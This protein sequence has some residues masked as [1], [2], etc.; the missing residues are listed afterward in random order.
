MRFLCSLFFLFTCMHAEA[1]SLSSAQQQSLNGYVEFANRSVNDVEVRFHSLKSYAEEA[2]YYRKHKGMSLRLGSSGPLEEYYFNNALKKNTLPAG[3]A[4][5]LNT[6]ARHLRQIAEALDSKCK[7]LETYIRLE[8]YKRDDLE[9]SDALLVEI[10]ALFVQFSL[11]KESFQKQIQAVYRRHQPENDKDVYLKTE[12]EMVQVLEKEKDLLKA[13]NYYFNQEKPASWPLELFQKN[14]LNN[15]STLS[16]FGKNQ[17]V[18]GYP[19]ANVVSS[20]KAAIESMQRLK[21]NAIDSYTF[22]ARQSGKHGNKV[23]LDLIN[24]YN[25]DLLANYQAFVRYSSVVKYLLDYPKF[26]LV[27]EINPP[28]ISKPAEAS[29]ESFKDAPLVPIAKIYSIPAS[30]TAFDALS[31]YVEYINESLRQMNRLQL[32]LRNYQSSAEYYRDPATN[33]KRSGLTY[34]HE[35]Y[36]MPLSLYQQ[37]ISSSQHLPKEYRTTI[38]SQAE[39]LMNILKEMDGLSIELIAYTRDKKYQQDQLRRS[40]AILERYAFLFDAFDQKKEQLYHDVRRIHESYQVANPKDSWYVSGKALLATIDHDKEILFGVKAYLKGETSQLPPIDKM[41]ASVRALITDEY[42]NLKGLTRYGRSNGLCPYSPYEDLASNSKRFGEKANNLQN[43]SNKEPARAYEDFYYFYNNEL[44]YEYNKFSEL[45]KVGVLKYIN[46]P[47][48]FIWKKA[49]PKAFRPVEKAPVLEMKE[50]V[51]E[52]P[53]ALNKPQKPQPVE[54]KPAV[55]HEL[56]PPVKVVTVEVAKHDTVYL[57]RERVDTVYMDRG[58]KGEDFNS[59]KGYAP[60]NMVLL[61]DVSASMD[62]PNKMPLLKKSIK[63]LL[64]LMRP[65]DEVSIVVYSGKAK[66]ALEPTSGAEIDKIAHVIDQLESDG[67]TDG[68]AG[69]RLAYKVANKNYIRGGNNRIVLATDGEFPI[70]QNAYQWAEE[71]AREDIYLTVF[72]FSRKAAI[73]GNLQKLS[74]KGRGSY[75]HITKE[76]AHHKLV[77]EAKA[78][79][80]R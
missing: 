1:Q 78:K 38:L 9:Q 71:N 43:S 80:A 39:V 8:D 24:Y 2:D 75:E 27:F 32:L 17:A 34:S 69:I 19:A 45:A 57:E 3:E 37:I 40:D 26:S 54:A 65:E 42:Q 33:V 44:V 59:L 7:A 31:L 18:I 66:V 25:N 12:K 41:A 68:N 63:S 30:K 21:R 58:Q 76:N 62:S 73:A 10:Q 61:L 55:V 14:V 60:N 11:Q 22:E 5:A 50:P 72:D 35:E 46:Q 49:E 64:A 28:S 16:T 79:K 70:S 52:A 74:Q 56:N 20:F 48:L 23:Y 13:W 67:G 47:N 4:Q 6:G 53:Q 36:K 51:N 77:T 29:T 15:E